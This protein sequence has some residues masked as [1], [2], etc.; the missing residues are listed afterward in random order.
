VLLLRSQ[1]FFSLDVPEE[2]REKTIKEIPMTRRSRPGWI[3]MAVV[4]VA[5]AGWF[6]SKRGSEIAAADNEGG[7]I[8]STLHRETFVLNLA[9]PDQKSYLRVG[10]DL[11]L[12]REA[13]KGENALPVA[14]VRDTILG[15]IGLAKVEELRLPAF[16]P[17]D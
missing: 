17:Q 11:G 10:I 15:V 4:L 16:C 13:G 2:E 9:D 14:P 12:N 7:R 3:L 6:W 5:L 8:K 1:N